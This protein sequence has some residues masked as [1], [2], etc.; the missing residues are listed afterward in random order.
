VRPAAANRLLCGCRWSRSL[1]VGQVELVVTLGSIAVVLLIGLGVF[2]VLRRGLRPI[3]AMPAQADRVTAGDLTDRVG[4]Y[5]PASEVGRLGSALNGML[6]RIETAVLERE[7][8]QELMRQ[9]FG[10]QP[11]AAHPAGLAACQRRALPA[12]RGDRTRPARRGHATHRPGDPADGPA[13]R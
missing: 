6:A 1:V 13:G 4:P 8:D 9:F 5:D 2:V 7:A 10:R 12:G 11:R 3:E